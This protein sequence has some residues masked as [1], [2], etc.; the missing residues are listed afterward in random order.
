MVANNSM[1]AME[2]A[3]SGIA[4]PPLAIEARKVS[5]TATVYAVFAIE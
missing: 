2:K 5:R 3:R 4:A 1:M